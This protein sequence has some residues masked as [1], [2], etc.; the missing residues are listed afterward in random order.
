MSDFAKHI[1]ERENFSVDFVNRLGQGEAISTAGVAI[2]RLLPGG[3]CEDRTD[4]FVDGAAQISGSEV[5]FTLKKEAASGDQPE[6]PYQV[7]TAITTAQGREL[8]DI[9]TMDVTA[10]AVCPE[11]P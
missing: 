3:S 11:T 5:T 8:V 2:I 4:E 7:K 9:A 1:G 10:Q 6:G